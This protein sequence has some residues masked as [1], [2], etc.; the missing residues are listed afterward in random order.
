[1][2]PQPRKGRYGGKQMRS[3][4][5]IDFAR[6]C[7]RMGW[8]WTYE[9]RDFITPF[10][11][12]RPDFAVTYPGTKEPVWFEVKPPGY[13]AETDS[14]TVTGLQHRMETILASEPGATLC[15]CIWEQGT[16]EPL[17][18][19]IGWLAPEL[20]GTEWIEVGPESLDL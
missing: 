3:Q 9:P 15:L 5:E 19:W 1:M 18:Q 14:L 11:R 2:K 8:D 16:D 7:D 17:Q 10:E 4:L 13:F 20:G 12:Y 6:H